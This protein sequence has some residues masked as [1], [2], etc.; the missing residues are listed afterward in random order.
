MLLLKFHEEKIR[1]CINKMSQFKHIQQKLF[2]D[3]IGILRQHIVAATSLLTSTKSMKQF[4]QFHWLYV[5]CFHGK[6]IINEVT[7]IAMKCFSHTS[8]TSIC[9]WTGGSKHWDLN[10][11][12]NR[13]TQFPI[14]LKGTAPR[15]VYSLSWIK[16]SYITHIENATAV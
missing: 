8:V 15:L 4:T 16:C 11:L 3:A 14:H 12:L 13:P 5:V 10:K 1:R 2:N 9:F 6:Q 7:Y